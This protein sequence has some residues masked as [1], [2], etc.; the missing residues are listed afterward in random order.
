MA[1]LSQIYADTRITTL[2]KSYDKIVFGRGQS[3]YPWLKLNQVVSELNGYGEK[4]EGAGEPTFALH[5]VQ[6]AMR[7]ILNPE[8]QLLKRY[9]IE[10]PRD[11]LVEHSIAVLEDIIL[12]PKI[13]DR[14]DFNSPVDPT[15]IEQY[16]IMGDGKEGFIWNQ[17]N[18][19]RVVMAAMKARRIKA[20]GI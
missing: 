6:V 12:V 11:A 15:I 13:G 10:Q 5:P 7:V 17:K 4:K 18:P 19:L 8:K 9:G 16:E 3:R 14:F 20:T 1:I 2:A